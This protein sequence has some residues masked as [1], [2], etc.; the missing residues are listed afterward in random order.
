[1]NLKNACEVLKEVVASE[2]G[3]KGSTGS[4]TIE[5]FVAAS[6]AMLEEDV[7][8]NRRQGEM[9]KTGIH[10][11]VL[12]LSVRKLISMSFMCFSDP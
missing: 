9:H 2:V 6:E 4:S 5:A 8:A 1:M 3:R 10:C 7:A 11:V 12:L